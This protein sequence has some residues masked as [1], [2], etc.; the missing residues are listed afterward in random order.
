MKHGRSVSIHLLQMASLLLPM[1]HLHNITGNELWLFQV[2]TVYICGIFAVSFTYSFASLRHFVLF[3]W[4]NTPKWCTLRNVKQIGVTWILLISIYGELNLEAI[5]FIIAK[6]SPLVLLPFYLQSTAVYLS[7]L[8]WSLAL[9]WVVSLNN[10][11]TFHGLRENIA[12][13]F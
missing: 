11:L 13:Y 6:K 8:L 2:S 3:C 1:P 4:N 5:N 9:K 7:I 12:K 10:D